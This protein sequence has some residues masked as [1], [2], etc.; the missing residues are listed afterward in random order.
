[1]D[2]T[3]NF[4]QLAADYTAGRPAYADGLIH[5][6]YTRYG[7][8]TQSVIADIGA[9][10]GKLSKQLLDRGS[11]VYAIEPNDDMRNTAIKELKSYPGFHPVKGSA[12]DTGLGE[13]TIDFITVAQAFHWFATLPFQKE[14]QRILRKQGLVFLIWNMRDM[15]HEINQKCFELF[16]SYCPK[17]KGFGG[18]IKRDDPRIKEFFNRRYEYVEFDHP[19]SYDR[20][21]FIH[22][23]LSGSYSLRNG[24]PDFHS[25]LDALQQLYTQY[26]ADNALIMGNKTVAYIGSVR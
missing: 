16:S 1:M 13:G 8:S 15:N 14:C 11:R 20:E 5:L 23:S 4:S 25:Y 2:N 7:L 19:I 9:G 17:F 26:A 6:L 3:Q 12:E 18:G 24:D 21:T 22:R 10:T